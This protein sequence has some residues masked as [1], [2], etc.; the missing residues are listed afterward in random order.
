MN[1][2]PYREPV[3]MAILA[4]A[5]DNP[6]EQATHLL[7]G[8]DWCEDRGWRNL[9]EGLR[10]LVY[11]GRR[12]HFHQKYQSWYWR[13]FGSMADRATL[14]PM[15]LRELKGAIYGDKTKYFS[16]YSIAVIAAAMAML[17]LSTERIEQ[18]KGIT[19]WH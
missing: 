16:S 2:N 19:Q 1:D 8:A 7:I 12:P 17:T 11:F 13:G 4:E 3:L 6:E 9:A 18:I 14:P 15:V 10:R 5:R